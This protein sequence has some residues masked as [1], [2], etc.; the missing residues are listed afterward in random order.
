VLLGNQNEDLDGSRQTGNYAVGGETSPLHSLAHPFS[1]YRTQ[2]IQLQI[3]LSFRSDSAQLNSSPTFFFW[4][5]R[6][7][8]AQLRNNIIIII[9]FG[10]S[11]ASSSTLFF[12]FFVFLARAKRAHRVRTD[13]HQCVLRLQRLFLFQRTLSGSDSSLKCVHVSIAYILTPQPN[14]GVVLSGENSATPP[15]FTGARNVERARASQGEL[16]RTGCECNR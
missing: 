7:S 16:G 10:Q 1:L 13:Q 2:R 6:H 15:L 9:I 11:R 14:T 4:P 3:P 5:A 12:V 8:T